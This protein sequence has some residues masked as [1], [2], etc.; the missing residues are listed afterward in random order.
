MSMQEMESTAIIRSSTEVLAQNSRSFR[1]ASLFLPAKAQDDAALCYA[2]CRLI[3]DTA[4]EAESVELARQELAQIRE[5]LAGH[6]PARALLATFL[7]MAKRTGL[8]LDCVFELIKGV[9]SDLGPVRLAN[10]AELLRYGYRVAGTVGLM[11]CAVLGVDEREALPH[12]IDL[13][14]AMQITNICRD[15]LEDA[16]MNRVY[17]PASRL[18][19]AGIDAEQIVDESVDREA[20]SRVLNELIELAEAYYLSGQNGMRFIPGRSRIGI[21]VAGRVYR[22]IGMRL[23]SQGGDPFR[24]RCVVPGW[25]K[26]YWIGVACVGWLDIS[27]FGARRGH[28]ATLHLLLS[29]LPGV[30]H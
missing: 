30:T 7:A 3:D 19:A 26:S 28:D 4:D 9:E 8:R 2:V 24:G 25:A 1:L 6:V 22:A 14:I 13:G 11:M 23:R 12:A 16:R 18:A 27:L 5:E 17:L 15:V 20:L 29:D 21:L 10:D